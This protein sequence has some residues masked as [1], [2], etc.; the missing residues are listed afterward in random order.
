MYLVK[1][2]K[3]YHIYYRDENGVLKTKSTNCSHKSEAAKFA[4]EYNKNP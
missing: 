2:K 3:V 1:R 4:Y